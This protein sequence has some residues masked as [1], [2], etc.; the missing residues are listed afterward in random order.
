M[1][2]IPTD[3]LLFRTA[4]S[5]QTITAY[6]NSG[7]KLHMQKTLPAKRSRTPKVNAAGSK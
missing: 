4:E 3:R 7:V 5:A 2:R 1:E 6:N